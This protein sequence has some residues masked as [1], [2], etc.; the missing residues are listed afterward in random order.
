MVY[1]IASSDNPNAN[2][3]PTYPMWPPASTALPTP[4]KTRTKVPRNSARY[5][6]KEGDL[7]LKV[8][9]V[10]MSV[11]QARRILTRAADRPDDADE[12]ERRASEVVA[13]LAVT[14]C[15]PGVRAVPGKKW[16][17]RRD[18]NPPPSA[19]KEETL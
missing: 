11:K 8:P 1:T 15:S 14:L 10:Y 16:R 17:A 4:P 9:G 6:R 13:Y 7:L 19:S 12:S 18:S 3:T 5:F 2:A